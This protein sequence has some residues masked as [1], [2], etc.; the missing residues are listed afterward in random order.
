MYNGDSLFIS[1][2]ELND[3]LF[4][5]IVFYHWWLWL[6]LVAA[7]K[8]R[9]QLVG[10]T[11][12]RVRVNRGEYPTTIMALA[13]KLKMNSKTVDDYLSMLVED[14]R[15]EVNKEGIVT[16]IKIV[17]YDQYTCHNSDRAAS[18]LSPRLM[19]EQVEQMRK[20]LEKELREQMSSFMQSD[21]LTGLRNEIRSLVQEEVQN[22]MQTSMP[23]SLEGSLQTPAQTP[24]GS[25]VPSSSSNTPSSSIVVGEED[26]KI[27][28]NSSPAPSREREIEFYEKLKNADEAT[29]ASMMRTLEVGSREEVLAWMEKYMD[30][31]ISASRFHTDQ[32]DFNSN[33]LT[34]YRS[35]TKKKE[36]S[37]RHTNGR[38]EEKQGGRR[39]SVADRR[40]SEGTA[41]SP[42]DYD[43][44]F[45]TEDGAS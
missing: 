18:S 43:A 25:R 29:M 7:P 19:S 44:P 1:R 42:D 37:N 15:I 13:E 38:N 17:D 33:F 22:R 9:L 26:K 35:Y 39:G 16:I 32:K 30:Y 3:W 2:D 28:I 34:W 4:D 11:R 41:L 23:T 8:S 20:N 10:N 21:L 14:G 12:T 31:N 36:N 45:P 27:N 24:V 5:N 6:R 40:G